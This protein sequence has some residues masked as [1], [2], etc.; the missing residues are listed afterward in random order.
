[1]YGCFTCMFVCIPRAC[2]CSQRWEE[3]MHP[4]ELQLQMLLTVLWVLGLNLGPPQEQV[5]LSTEP[6]LWP[7]SQLKVLNSKS[8]FVFWCSF[9]KTIPILPLWSYF[10]QQR[11][12][13]DT[14]W[15]RLSPQQGSSQTVDSA[16][17]FV[18]SISDTFLPAHSTRPQA[19]GSVPK[20][21]SQDA[22]PKPYTVILGFLLG[23]LF[24]R[25]LTTP[26]WDD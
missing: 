5:L 10:S 11:R 22:N 12:V 21:A 1:M 17:C 19:E 24:I 16:Q 25:G 3:A 18:M 14:R 7:H 4:L 15:A 13:I 8:D 9:R 2:W 6:F 23:W 20:V 26:S